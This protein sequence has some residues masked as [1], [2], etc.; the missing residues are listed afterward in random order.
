MGAA[1]SQEFTDTYEVHTIKEVI[2]E[3]RDENARTYLQNLPFELVIHEFVEDEW[4]DRVRSFAKE[5]GDFKTLSETDMRVMALGLQLAE[6][7]GEGDRIQKAPKPLAEFRPKRFQEDYKRIEEG[8]VDDS[9]EETDSDQSGEEEQEA[10]EA[11]LKK[12][13]GKNPPEGFGFGDD[14][15]FQ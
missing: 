14:D 12:T 8:E 7:R 9:D 13:R 4:M 6:E 15:G 5:T 3:I 2:K 1:D 10:D 11:S